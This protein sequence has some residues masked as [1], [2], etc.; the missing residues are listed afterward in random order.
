MIDAR[1]L[2]TTYI[3]TLDLLIEPSETLKNEA[4]FSLKRHG[5]WLIIVLFARL[6]YMLFIFFFFCV[7]LLCFYHPICML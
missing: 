6:I 2:R 5:P 4:R 7:F 1:N 3:H